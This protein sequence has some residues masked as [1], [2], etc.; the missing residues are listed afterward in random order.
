MSDRMSLR[1][2]PRRWGAAVLLWAYWPRLDYA[3]GLALQHRLHSARGRAEIPDVLLVTEHPATVTLGRRGSLADLPLGPS[4]LAARGIALYQV[5]RGGRATFHRPGQLV[6]YPIVDL[7]ALQIGPRR[8]VETLERAV[9]HVLRASGI[10]A[11]GGVPMPGVWVGN[12]KIAAIGVEILGGI[13]RHGLSL[14]LAG[15]LGPFDFMVQ[16]GIADARATSVDALGVSPPRAVEVGAALAN[17]LGAVLGLQPRQADV[18]SLLQETRQP[19][20]TGSVSLGSLG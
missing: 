13:S 1:T 19:R 17:E 15:E 6:A 4:A 9:V 3:S 7:R 2:A 18:M 10:P 11:E 12:R 20:R 5:S 14:N 8:F 16:C